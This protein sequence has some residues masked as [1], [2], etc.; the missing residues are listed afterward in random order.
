LY[1]DIRDLSMIERKN[2]LIYEQKIESLKSLP[3]NRS[4][5]LKRLIQNKELI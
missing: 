2:Q 3:E 1:K 5:K 4:S